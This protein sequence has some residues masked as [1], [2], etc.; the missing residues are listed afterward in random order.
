MSEP[1][2]RACHNQNPPPGIL[3]EPTFLPDRH[4][5]KLGLPIPEKTDVLFPDANNDGVPDANYDCVNCHEL[6]FDPIAQNFVLSDLS[7][8][9][10]CHVYSA[11]GSVH[12][13]S[14]KTLSLD[15][16]ACHGGLVNNHPT[17][18]SNPD[19]HYIPTYSPSALT[20]W[21]S[22]KPGG[23]GNQP[24]SSAGTYP[25]NCDYCHNTEDGTPNGGAPIQTPIGMLTID[26]NENTHHTAAI[27]SLQ[28]PGQPPCMVCHDFT[29]PPEYRIR[30]C[31]NCHGV[32]TLH[33]I[34]ADTNGDGFQFLRE[35]PGFSHVG[36]L[37]DC[38]GC[39]STG[40]RALAD[41]LSA[42]TL[43]GIDFV[44][45]SAIRAGSDSNITISGTNFT[46]HEKNP[47]T[48]ANDTLVTSVIRLI[49]GEGNETELV[50]NSVTE[51]SI[52][53]TVPGSMAPGNYRL[54][55]DKKGSESTPASLIIK[56]E[57][58]SWQTIQG[59]CPGSW[60]EPIAAVWWVFSL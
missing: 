32:D 52:Q 18:G 21:P 2:C 37:S 11:E 29:S 25:G 56:P 36:S 38:W 24:P 54:V 17:A 20:P 5:L 60:R 10:Q 14:D 8:C 34:I 12:H 26:T 59:G 46:G 30:T 27:G 22:G 7:D 48:G 49:D 53:V 44:N 9:M 57:V 19:G 23:N 51:N 39:H 35:A 16:K 45:G 33:A 40:A 41:K 4:H 31:E 28:L 58:K 15:C 43:P 13:R 50:P 1:V 6:T 42:K 55:V 3:A 47:W